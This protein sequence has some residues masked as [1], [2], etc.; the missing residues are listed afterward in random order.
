MGAS[1]ESWPLAPSVGVCHASQEPEVPSPGEANGEDKSGEDKTELMTPVKPESAEKAT[2]AESSVEEPAK[3][4]PNSGDKRK[5]DNVTP[6]E[7]E[8]AETAASGESS[9]EEPAKEPPNS[10]EKRKAD[11]DVAEVALADDGEDAKK[12]ATA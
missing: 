12:A 10:G 5:A 2:S 8:S 1:L 3:E 9:V 6:V 7:P 11:P 4:A